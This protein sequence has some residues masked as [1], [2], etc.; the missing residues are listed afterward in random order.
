M[1][2]SRWGAPYAGTSRNTP[3]GS[4]LFAAFAPRGIGA[5][6][7]SECRLARLG[8]GVRGKGSP[9][10]EEEEDV[11]IDSSTNASSAG[12]FLCGEE[13]KFSHE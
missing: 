10:A 3:A 9:A 13:P 4:L 8:A 2:S 1:S 6:V 11:V 7:S 12:S 5:A